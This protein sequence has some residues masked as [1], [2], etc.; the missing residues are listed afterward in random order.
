M[1]LRRTIMGRTTFSGPAAGSY[2][3]FTLGV[4]GSAETPGA[5]TDGEF[6]RIVLPFACRIMEIG[7]ACASSASGASR[8]T[9]QITDG[10]NDLISA[11]TAIVSAGTKVVTPTSTQKLV[12]AQ[13]TRAKGDVLV[14]TMTTVASEV[15]KGLTATITVR[16]DGHVVALATDD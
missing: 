16:V 5:V 10:T 3:T 6:G 8:P 1:P 15:I 7:L 12:A 13:R 14:F 4:I 2:S 9:V 11:D